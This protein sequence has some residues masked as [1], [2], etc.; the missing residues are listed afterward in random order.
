MSVLVL[1]VST[2]VELSLKGVGSPGKE[3]VNYSSMNVR[4]FVR[5]HMTTKKTYDHIIYILP[6]KF[7]FFE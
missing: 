6:K 1:F 5:T 3:F 2:N 7:F 4:F